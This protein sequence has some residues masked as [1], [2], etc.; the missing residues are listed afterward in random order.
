MEDYSPQFKNFL[1]WEAISRDHIDVKTIYIDMAGGDHAAGIFLSQLVYW[2]LIPGKDGRSKLRVF[3]DGYHWVAKARSEWYDEIRLRPRQFDRVSELLEELEIIETKTYKFGGIPKTHTRIVIE[4]FFEAWEK[5][6]E[7]DTSELPQGVKSTSPDREVHIHRVTQDK[8]KDLSHLEKT[9]QAAPSVPTCVVCGKTDKYAAKLPADV[10]P[11]ERCAWC[12]ILD[13]WAHIFKIRIPRRTGTSTSKKLRKRAH[14]RM[15]EDDFKNNWIF[16]LQKARRMKHITGNGWFNMA[17]L[18]ANDE[19]IF[20][21]IGESGSPGLY[22]GFE[23]QQ[24]P[25]SYNDL[26]QWLVLR[27]AGLADQQAQ[28]SS[29]WSQYEGS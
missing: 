24:H 2:Y 3:R 12:F 13:G 23:K 22:D 14:T 9:T 17:F 4:K 27:A 25:H 7:V 1:A 18:L 5:F 28:A 29:G 15:Q 11:Q 26:Q 10:D 21:V 16:A 8:E 20:R 6:A 19:H